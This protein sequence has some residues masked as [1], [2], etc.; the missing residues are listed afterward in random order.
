MT[1]TSTRPAGSTPEPLDR[2]ARTVIAVVV[3][4]MITTVLDATIVS[5]ATE[6]LATGFSVPL[7]TIQWVMT[8]YLLAFTAAIPVTG[9]AVDRYGA[10]PV[11]LSAVGLF[12]AGSLLCGLAWS[13]ESLIAFRVLQGL[14][15]G[16]VTPVG[17]TMVARAVGQHRMGRAM[18]VVG[19]PMMLG[20]ILGPVV[21]GVL[22]DTVD[23]RWIFFVNL[24]IGVACLVWSRRV[25]AREPG[26]QQ[27]RLDVL[28]LALLSPG[29]GRTRLRRPPRLTGD[30]SIDHRSP[31]RHRGRRRSGR[32]VRRPRAHGPSA[33]GR[34]EPLPPAG[35]RN[36]H[37]RCS[38]SRS[39]SLTGAM[40]LLPLYYL[41]AR[42]QSEL[43]TGLL[44]VPQG[45]GA[46]L[47]MAA[48]GKLVD[49][50]YG[51]LVVV[52]GTALLAVGFL[53]YTQVGS[54]YVPVAWLLVALFE[55]RPRRRLIFAPH[56]RRGVRRPRP[57]RHPAGDDDHEHRPAHRW[58]DRDGDLRRRAAE[59]PVRHHRPGRC[60]RGQLLVAARGCG[61]RRRPRS[62]P[63]GTPPPREG[64]SLMSVQL[65]HTI[66]HASDRDA[67][68]AFLTEVLGL[69]EAQ[70]YGPFRVV[71]VANGVSLDV[72]HDPGTFQS[73]HY[74]FLVGE[75]E[76][77][78]ILGRITDRG[79]TYWADPFHRQ[80]GRST[81]TTA[82]AASTGTTRTATSWRSSR[83]RTA[84]SDLG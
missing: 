61:A 31:G 68:A 55:D 17:I 5:V 43:E 79:L 70:E 3:L 26:R 53:G 1:Q 24:P 60:L 52:T 30:G 18:A 10:R 23:W 84:A 77:D 35:V 16:M 33:P 59:Q 74:A 46:A 69:P 64:S 71:E 34:P 83:C 45:V 14:G 19:I 38:S 9:W 39:A 62:V 78:A 27:E 57:R 42:G 81:T 54:R 29:P 82:A 8:G 47:A 75:D 6:R 32:R 76:F 4:G 80:A 36:R 51:R 58:R 25:L 72:M 11:W 12:T 40:F 65:N 48:T 28:G 67:T 15:A 50:G 13:A 37:G 41:V 21:G 2:T 73:Q 44:L 20:P 66:V 63:A 7:T 49:R 22:V 56:H